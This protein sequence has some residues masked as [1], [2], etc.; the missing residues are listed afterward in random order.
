[1]KKFVLGLMVLVC[2]ALAMAPAQAELAALSINFTNDANLI[3]PTDVA[4]VGGLYANWN[5]MTSGT[6]YTAGGL[7]LSTGNS[8]T[9]VAIPQFNNSG[10]T[11][12]GTPTG[13]STADRALMAGGPNIHSIYLSNQQASSFEIT[14]LSSIFPTGY[15][16]IVYTTYESGLGDTGNAFVSPNLSDINFGTGSGDGTWRT[17]GTTVA[18]WG[19]TSTFGGTYSAG[20]NY[21]TLAAPSSGVGVDGLVITLD[22]QGPYSSLY[23]A[24][25]SAWT[26]IQ[27][28]GDYTPPPT[29]SPVAE[30]AGLGLLGVALLALRK[31]RS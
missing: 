29:E 2:L 27:I 25:A 19:G 30:P 11:A 16:I 28:I 7:V 31:R 6:Q 17:T 24:G 9:G 18:G 5:N 13:G 10:Y 20:T 22:G 4:G 1:M 15:S 26:G 14:G 8:A 23:L 21:V 12:G 3:A